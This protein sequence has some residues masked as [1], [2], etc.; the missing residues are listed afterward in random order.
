MACFCEIKFSVTFQHA[1]SAK[2]YV[3]SH[4]N[5]MYS[6]EDILWF[7]VVEVEK[8]AKLDQAR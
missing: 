8:Y 4:A 1:G 2:K 7:L 3:I 5:C 6:L